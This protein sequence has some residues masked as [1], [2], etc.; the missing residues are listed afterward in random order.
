M[1]EEKALHGKRFII[2][3]REAANCEWMY[4]M[5]RVLTYQK[6]KKYSLRKKWEKRTSQLREVVEAFDRLIE[7]Y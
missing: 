7:R 6:D 4:N 2:L 1:S 3:L 5:A